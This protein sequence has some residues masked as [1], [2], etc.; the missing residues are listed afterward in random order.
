MFFAE[1]TFLMRH[2]LRL[3][4][5]ERAAPLRVT[6]TIRESDRDSNN[7]RRNIVEAS[8]YVSHGTAQMAGRG[9]LFDPVILPH[10]GPGF[11]LSGI[12]LVSAD[13]GAAISEVR[14]TWLVVPVLRQGVE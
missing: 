4:P 7:F 1:V 12:E 10:A 14:Q 13:A 11:L 2:G 9:R 5:A 8:L 6:V 3:K